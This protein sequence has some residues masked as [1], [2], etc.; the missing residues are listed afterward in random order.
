MCTVEEAM[1]T[2]GLTRDAYYKWFERDE[3]GDFARW[4]QHEAEKWAGRQLPRV[5]GAVVDA[6]VRDKPVGS[7][8]DRRTALERFDKGFAPKSRT[9]SHVSGTVDVNLAELSTDELGRLEAA[10]RDGADMP[11]AMAQARQETT[12]ND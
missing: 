9:E 10:L 8:V 11:A 6:A 5:Y 2:A 1:Q 4:W 12:D 3:S 7:A